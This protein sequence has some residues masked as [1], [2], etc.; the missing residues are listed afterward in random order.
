MKSKEE[1]SDYACKYRSCQITS[2]LENY[3]NKINIQEN[4]I[5][6]KNSS[7]KQKKYKNT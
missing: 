3:T 6:Y 4:L 1:G 5:P 2:L 7:N